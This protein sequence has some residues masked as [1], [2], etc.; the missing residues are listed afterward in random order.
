MGIF[1]R[2]TEGARRTMSYAQESA[3]Q[4]GRN[5]V[6]SEDLLIGLLRV[7][8]SVAAKALARFGVM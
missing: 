7:S 2:F 5:Y 8:D 3:K 6:G 1:D 4:L